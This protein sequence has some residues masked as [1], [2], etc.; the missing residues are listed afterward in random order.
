MTKDEIHPAFFWIWAALL[1]AAL[2]RLD[3]LLANLVA[4]AAILIMIRALP[5]RIFRPRTFLIS[6]KLAL[7]A[8]AIRIFFALVIGVPMPG[9]TI[10]TLPELQLPDFLVGIRLGGEVTTQRLIGALKEASLFSA[11]IIAFGGANSLT[12]PTRL[13]KV[14]PNRV[15]GVG[16]ATTIATT[17]TPQ[18]ANS[19]TRIKQAQFFRGQSA[20]GFRSWSRISTPVLEDSLARAVDLAAALEARGYGAFS[21]PTRYR[22]IE[23]NLGHSVAI[24]PILYSAILLPSLTLAPLAVMVIFAASVVTPAVLG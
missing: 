2:I 5:R 20:T 12:T 24:A 1:V 10:F 14:L 13:L 21:T 19:V 16:V 6:L 17:L 7:A 18:L 3:E 15:Y 23:W 11:L 8:T 4:I 22:P 9:Q